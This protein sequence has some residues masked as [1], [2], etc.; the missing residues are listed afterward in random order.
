MNV[1]DNS[2]LYYYLCG[3][4]VC[5]DE[6]DSDD[7]FKDI[8]SF[9]DSHEEEVLQSDLLEALKSL[10]VSRTR[11]FPDNSV[12]VLNETLDQHQGKK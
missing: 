12:A 3:F 10:I 2:Y 8:W 7:Y 5:S 4:Q 6:I 1:I 9:L 11:I